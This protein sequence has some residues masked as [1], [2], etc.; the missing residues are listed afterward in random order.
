M[1]KRVKQHW[2]PASARMTAGGKVHGPFLHSSFPP[3]QP[4]SSR[5]RGSM[6]FFMSLSFHL[7]I[8]GLIIFIIHFKHESI[9]NTIGNTEKVYL[10]KE[11]VLIDKQ[12]KKN[13]L[14]KTWIPAAARARPVMLVK[15]GMT[16]KEER[17][18]S[19]EPK[20]AANNVTG[21]QEAL[22]I[23]LHNI[24]QKQFL[25]YQDE[26][27]PLEKKTVTVELDLSSDGK[28]FN[29]TLQDDVPEE[30]KKEFVSIIQSLSPL[31]S[32]PEPLKEEQHFSLQ[33]KVLRD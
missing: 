6:P 4:S 2:I 1:I 14:K 24:I 28:L 33:V 10:V 19:N 7:F 23:Y 26:I 8:I 22:L 12:S 21:K 16:A 15:T 5:T 11:N 25:L 32:I 30:I 31:T 18:D 9:K 17:S 3:L 27:L 13:K 29:I 20:E